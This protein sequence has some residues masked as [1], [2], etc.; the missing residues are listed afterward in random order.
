MQPAEWQSGTS[1]LI[2]P[3]LMDYCVV[4]NHVALS[5]CQSYGQRKADVEG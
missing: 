4:C 2:L 3:S 1:T 5:T